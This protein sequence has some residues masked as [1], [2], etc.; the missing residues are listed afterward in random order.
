MPNFIELSGGTIVQTGSLS[1]GVISDSTLLTGSG[2][3]PIG[4]GGGGSSNL[5][6]KSATVS[7]VHGSATTATITP[8]PGYDG[9]D[10]VDLTISPVADGS[11]V[12]DNYTYNNSS[13]FSFNASTGKITSATLYQNYVLDATVTPGY[14]SSA[15]KGELTVYLH[16]EQQLDTVGAT[17]YYPSTTDQTIATQKY[18]TGAQTIKGVTYTNLT[19]SNIV[20][21]VTVMIGDSADPDRIVSVT[22]TAQVGGDVWVEQTIATDGAVSQALDPYTLYHFTGNLTSLTITLTA[23]SAGQIAHYHFDF[24]SGS[25][26]PTLTMPVTVTMPD[27]FAVEASKRYEVDVLNNFGTV[28]EWAN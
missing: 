23:P 21:G 19:A 14:V 6:T 27:S 17:T 1:G 5:Q 26:A 13:P 12:V 11:V 3:Y 22:G 2:A 20:S 7:S 18:L 24:L 25:T 10:E 8:D 9:M 28:V 16:K 4:S 15:T